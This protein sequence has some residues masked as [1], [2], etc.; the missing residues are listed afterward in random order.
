[1][2]TGI[3]EEIGTVR[4]LE[5]GTDSARLNVLAKTACAETR[6]GDSVAVNGVCL[7]VTRFFRGGFTA[8][9]MAETLTRTSLANLRSG[10]RVNL[11]RALTLSSRVGGHLVSGH[12]DGTGII[13]SIRKKGIAYLYQIECA[14]A[15]LRYIIEKGSVALD[16]ISLTV[17]AVSDTGFDVSIIPHTAANTILWDKKTGDKINIECDQLAKYQEKQK[18]FDNESNTPPSKK[19]TELFLIQNGFMED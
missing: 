3:I 13:L 2:F 14:P 18:L 16:G 15:L 11:E 4:S 17:C 1:M 8:D 12:I 9:I 6:V 7:T 5:R 19:I 10:S